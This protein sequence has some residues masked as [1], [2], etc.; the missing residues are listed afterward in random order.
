MTEALISDSGSEPIAVMRIIVR[1]MM[2]F[3]LNRTFFITTIKM[4]VQSGS[5][6]FIRWV[7]EAVVLDILAFVISIAYVWNI[8]RKMIFLSRK[9]ALNCMFLM[10]MKMK[11]H[12]MHTYIANPAKLSRLMDVPCILLSLQVGTSSH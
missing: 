12:K 3:G 1:M 2:T 11:T 10:L 7:C 9:R 6:I 8:P 5:D 4:V